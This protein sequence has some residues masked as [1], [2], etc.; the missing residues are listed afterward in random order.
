MILQ[1]GDQCSDP[2]SLIV[3]PKANGFESQFLHLQNR[4]NPD[5]T[6]LRENMTGLQDYTG[7]VPGS[8]Q[9]LSK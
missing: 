5:M 7:K 1:S 2:S 4:G 3:V 9:V 6:G 8:I